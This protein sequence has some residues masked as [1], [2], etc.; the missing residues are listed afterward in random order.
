M[1][2]KR[3]RRPKLVVALVAASDSIAL[4]FSPSHLY[5]ITRTAF[6]TG[7][8]LAVRVRKLLFE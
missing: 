1:M 2:M 4:P 7:A 5:L 8:R 6:V 3:F